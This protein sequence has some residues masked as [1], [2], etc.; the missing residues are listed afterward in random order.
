MK[1]QK[2]YST[3]NKI[4]TPKLYFIAIVTVVAIQG[5]LMSIYN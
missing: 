2:G 4:Q 1:Y 3:I 5:F